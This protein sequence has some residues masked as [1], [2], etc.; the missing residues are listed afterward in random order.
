MTELHRMIS[1]LIHQNTDH[2][3]CLILP[4]CQIL[5]SQWSCLHG[6]PNAV[7]IQSQLKAHLTGDGRA[8]GLQLNLQPEDTVYFWCL[9][10]SGG[11]WHHYRLNS[12]LIWFLWVLWY[13]MEYGFDDKLC[14]HTLRMFFCVHYIN[15]VKPML[16]YSLE[17]PGSFESVLFRSLI[18]HNSKNHSINS[19]LCFEWPIQYSFSLRTP[20]SYWGLFWIVTKYKPETVFSQNLK[21]LGRKCY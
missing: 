1:P 7:C 14:S 12:I 8:W 3:S 9:R 2:K 11:L 18:Q 20:C 10:T 5:T 6:I 13:D 21:S 15:Q 19:E 16:C 17:P 4:N